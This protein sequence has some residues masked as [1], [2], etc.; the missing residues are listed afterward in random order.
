MRLLALATT[1]AAA[2]LGSVAPGERLPVA[3]AFQGPGAQPTFYIVANVGVQSW[4]DANGKTSAQGTVTSCPVT[5][6]FLATFKWN[7]T[8]WVQFQYYWANSDSMGTTSPSV[9]TM[10][11]D[12][13]FLPTPNPA[14][15]GLV[16]GVQPSPF[17]TLTWTLGK[18]GP[19]ANAA[20]AN[21]LHWVAVEI[22][23]EI[24]A[25]NSPLEGPAIS[26]PSYFTLTC[27]TIGGKT[28]AGTI[29]KSSGSLTFGAP[30]TATPTVAP[31]PRVPRS[32]LP[33]VRS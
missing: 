25:T 15:T 23:S 29:Y 20:R 12:P 27:P 2:L 10:L 7:W 14:W 4:H 13:P 18:N 1:V 6:N 3:F 21:G 28:G 30:P 26:S 22:A 31:T 24:P 11:L 9:G 19:G 8:E 32:P 33:T 5:I 16:M 17:E